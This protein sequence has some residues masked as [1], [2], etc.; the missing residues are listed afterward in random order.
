ML[1]RLHAL[2]ELQTLQRGDMNIYQIV[3]GNAGWRTAFYDFPED[4]SRLVTW[5]HGV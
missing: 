4:A 3:S 1:Q 5:L 2:Q